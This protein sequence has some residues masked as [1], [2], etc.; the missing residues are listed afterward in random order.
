MSMRATPS[1]T[2]RVADIDIALD[3]APV[4]AKRQVDFRLNRGVA[5]TR[6]AIG[7]ASG[8]FVQLLSSDA[9]DRSGY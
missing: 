2:A 5:T 4:D 9:Q 1:P 3:Q 6:T 8:A 7:Q